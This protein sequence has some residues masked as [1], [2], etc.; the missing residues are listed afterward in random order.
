MG[1]LNDKPFY[2]RVIPAGQITDRSIGIEAYPLIRG[3][4]KYCPVFIPVKTQNPETYLIGFK[5]SNQVGD[6][7]NGTT[8][9]GCRQ[10]PIDT[11]ED[12]LQGLLRDRF[13]GDFTIINF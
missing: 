6:G 11:N 4:V 3:Y 13:G 7:L 8:R 5:L 1:R 10:K 2:Q 9:L 12:S